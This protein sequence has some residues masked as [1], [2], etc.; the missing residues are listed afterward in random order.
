MLNCGL[1]QIIFWLLTLS[2]NS[3]STCTNWK[4]ELTS[5]RGLLLGHAHTVLMTIRVK[6]ALVMASIAR[7]IMNAQVTATFLAVKL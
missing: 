1:V 4:G 6:S 3:I 2:K 5:N 7:Q